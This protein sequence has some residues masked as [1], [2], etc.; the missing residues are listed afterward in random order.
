[1]IFSPESQYALR[2]CVHVARHPAGELVPV[3]HIARQE[4]IPPAFIGR[5]SLPHT[6]ARRFVT[7]VPLLAAPAASVPGESACGAES[8][9]LSD[10]LCARSRPKNVD[11]FAQERR[12]SWGAMPG[13]PAAAA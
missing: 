11:N 12:A 8:P 5:K 1:M 9:E 7:C 2:A 3:Q 13:T 4:D 10:H 6:D